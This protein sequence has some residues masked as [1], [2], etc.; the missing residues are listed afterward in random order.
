MRVNVGRRVGA[1]LGVVAG[2]AALVAL[3]AAPAAASPLFDG[4]GRGPTAEVAVQSA[5]W[6]A[7]ITAQS[8]GFYGECAIVG[9]PAIFETFNDPNFGHVFRAQLTISCQR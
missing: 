1:G 9:T 2:A 3:A 6:D 7:Q 5:F 8:V 4:G